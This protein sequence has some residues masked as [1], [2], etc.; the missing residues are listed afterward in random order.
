MLEQ[1]A[2]CHGEEGVFI[3]HRLVRKWPL[4]IASHIA[5]FSRDVLWPR[6]LALTLVETLS[7]RYAVRV[8]SI[9]TSL[10]RLWRDCHSSKSTS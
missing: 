1:V 6:L 10:V 3:A 5:N 4:G 8:S 9:S 7:Q 2:L